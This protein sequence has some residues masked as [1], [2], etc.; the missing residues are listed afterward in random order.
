R[1]HGS[2]WGDRYHVR[3]LRTPREVRNALVYV[4][5]NFRKHLRGVVGIDPCSSAQW[6]DGFRGRDRV[7]QSASVLVRARSWLLRLVWRRAGL[8]DLEEAPA[9]GGEGRPKAVLC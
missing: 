3:A 2:V 9:R 6:F 1:R 5:Q 4:L 8:I 7:E